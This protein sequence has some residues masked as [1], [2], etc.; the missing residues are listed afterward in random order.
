M[1]EIIRFSLLLFD[2][3]LDTSLAPGSSSPVCCAAPSKHSRI[4]IQNVLH[5]RVTHPGPHGPAPKM[6]Y[7][8]P[9]TI[10]H[11]LCPCRKTQ[12]RCRSHID[13]SPTIAPRHAILISRCT[14]DRMLVG[15]HVSARFRSTDLLI[16]GFWFDIGSSCMAV[17]PLPASSTV[18]CGQYSRGIY[19]SIPTYTTRRTFRRRCSNTYTVL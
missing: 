19:A 3:Q 10:G 16:R 8:P 5:I 6:W 14:M 2:S 1:K 9:R 12:W 4:D 15:T 7:L 17:K 11:S 13:T 18:R